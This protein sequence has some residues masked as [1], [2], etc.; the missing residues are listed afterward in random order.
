[1]GD[2]TN[3][4]DS[5]TGLA[6]DSVI[7]TDTGFVWCWDE[8]P[9]SAGPNRLTK[10]IASTGTQLAVYNFSLV[11]TALAGGAEI[12]VYPGN[13]LRKTLLL[14]YQNFALV[15]YKMSDIL[16]YVENRQSMISG[17]SLNQNYPNPFNPDTKISFNLMK[18]KY[19]TLAVYDAAGKLVKTLLNQ[20]MQAG[21]HTVTF[22]ASN[23]ATGIYYYT[24][25]AGDFKDTKKMVLIK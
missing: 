3:S 5:K 10:F 2:I 24:I 4:Y 7:A 18:M 6:F 16:V 12:V 11:G 9:G 8:G 13:P 21:D 25:S 20:E 1:L 23:L 14:N 22:D 15:A 19:M 17:F